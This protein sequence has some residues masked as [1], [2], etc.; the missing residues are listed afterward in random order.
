M[1][2]PQPPLDEEAQLAAD[3][4]RNLL[5]LAAQQVVF[6]A[7][8][9][10]KTESVVMPAFLDA[11]SGAG[12]LRGFLPVLNRIGQS[13]PPMLMAERLRRMPRKSR[14]LLT[15][16]V[17]MSV[18]LLLLAGIWFLLEEKRQ[19]WLPGLFL[20]LYFVFFC[21]NGLNQL[22][23][24]AVH[25]K[26]IAAERRGRLLAISGVVG[27]TASIAAAW[28]LLPPLLQADYLP[29]F[30][31]IFA[32]TGF[33]FCLAAAV[34]LLLREPADRADHAPF[35]QQRLWQG[36]WLVARRDR[37]FR[38][39]AV[40]AMLF[41]TAQLLFPHY[42]KM[43]QIRLETSGFDLMVWVVAQ[44]AGT[45]VF[46]LLAGALADRF[47]NRLTIRVLVF[48][49]ALTPL[50]ALLVT[51]DAATGR[52]LFWVTF[53]LLGLIPVT[54]T[55]LV[56]YALEIAPRDDHPRYV[57]TLSL[58]LA[59]PFALSP[60]A[61]WLIDLVGFPPVL[62]AVSLLIALGG[63]LTFRMSEPRRRVAIIATEPFRLD[64][65]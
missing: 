61:G 19:P 55:A 48:A 38:R 4:P 64:E 65:T 28:F 11:I 35:R 39:L 22:A 21:L 41:I 1:R 58:C 18:P 8:W 5:V 57:S 42:Q 37:A 53:F 59:I 6:R 20:L 36:V 9:I 26:L 63:V 12:W 47:G 60:L 51:R 56:S 45:G 7:A 15:T 10:F 29:G 40:V 25:G 2:P 23:L 50:W 33:G 43:G 30:G 62:W 27:A 49:S 13:V 14:S 54:M 32:I 52:S 34:C 3:Q 24:G 46:S 31:W 16:S 17:T 44:N